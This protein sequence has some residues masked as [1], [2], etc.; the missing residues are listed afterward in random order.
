M[1]FDNLLFGLEIAVHPANLLAAFLGVLA[2]NLVGVLPGIGP[3]GAAAILF[4]LTLTMDPTSGVIMIAGIYFGSQFGGAIT[5]ILLRIPGEASSIAAMADGN[6]MAKAGRGGAA[7]GIAILGSFVAGTLAVVGVTLFTPLLTGVALAFRQPELF[8]LTAGGLLVV[9]TVV[10]KG[11]VR[12][13]LPMLWGALFASIGQDLLSGS[14]R[15]S[16]GVRELYDGLGV[17]AVAIGMFGIAELVLM[18][19]AIQRSTFI[20]DIRIREMFPNR[21]EL[22][23]A[24][25]AWGRGGALGFFIGLL[26]GPSSVL[27]AF[28]AYKVE[29]SISRRKD[30]FGKGAPEGIAGPE[31]ANNAAATAGVVP[32]LGLGIPFSATLAFMLAAMTSH[33]VTPGPLLMSNNPDIYWGVIAA[34]YVANIMLVLLNIPLINMWVRILLVPQGLL[35]PIILVLATYGAFV[36]ELSMFALFTVLGFAALALVMTITGFD[37]APFL[38]GFIVAPMVEMYGRQ[39]LQVGGGDPAYLI[40]GAIAPAIWAVVL[41]VLVVPPVLRLATSRRQRE[42]ILE[43]ADL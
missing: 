19:A 14:A 8:A 32:I 10:G 34:M 21:R 5:A 11:G 40:S 16:F 4:P 23:R 37:L 35:I 28:M 7:L 17:E 30:E 13:V 15:F 25:P 2:G 38:L 41:C 9:S 12:S 29:R 27:S 18:S 26:P 42:E 20:K 33:G 1:S 6:A 3:I 39:A 36:S 24:A 43:G 22:R 31:A